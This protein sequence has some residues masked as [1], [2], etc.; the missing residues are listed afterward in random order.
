[1]TAANCDLLSPAVTSSSSTSASTNTVSPC[2]QLFPPLH[3]TDPTTSYTAPL[4]IPTLSGASTEA[5]VATNP[6]TAASVAVKTSSSEAELDVPE[7][8][9]DEQMFHYVIM[10]LQRALKDCQAAADVS[11]FA[12]LGRFQQLTGRIGR[13]IGMA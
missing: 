2:I 13:T 8:E 7:F 12:R 4:I 9:D 5:S 11:Q 10:R 1:V 3:G 6:V